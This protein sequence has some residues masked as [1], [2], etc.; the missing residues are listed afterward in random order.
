[1]EEEREMER[2]S[3]LKSEKKRGGERER[4]REKV[5]NSVNRLCIM[6][7]LRITCSSYLAAQIIIVKSIYKD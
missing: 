6:S 3:V 7:R 1:V 2:G 5:R 4:E